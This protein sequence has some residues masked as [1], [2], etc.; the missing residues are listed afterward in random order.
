M[1]G[2]L[3]KWFSEEELGSCYQ[4]SK[5]EMGKMLLDSTAWRPW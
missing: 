2:K 4:L 5:I 3:G 1:G